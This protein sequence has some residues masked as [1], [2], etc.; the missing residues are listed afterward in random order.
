MDKQLDTKKGDEKSSGLLEGDAS[1]T[2]A[3]YSRP[4][5]KRLGKVAQMTAGPS[6]GQGESGQPFV[7]RS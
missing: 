1:A 5:I 3:S 6:F 2:K 4:T 7:Y